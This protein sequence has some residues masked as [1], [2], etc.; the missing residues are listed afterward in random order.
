MIFLNQSL[1]SKL[2][3]VVESTEEETCGFI[4]GKEDGDVRHVTSLM[5]VKNISSFNK[6][7]H[8]EIAAQDYLHAEYFAE[9]NNLQLLGVFHSHP[10]SPAL[11]SETDRLAAQPYFSYFILS[12]KNKKFETIRSW[13]LDERFQFQEESLSIIHTTNPIHGYRYHT[14][15]AA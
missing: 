1:L 6:K 8:F 15:T 13:N 2:Q 11:P 14:N 10:N 3:A 9:H 5:E 12:V 7:K 4:F